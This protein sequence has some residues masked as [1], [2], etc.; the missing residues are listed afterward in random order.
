[1]SKIHLAIFVSLL[2]AAACGSPLRQ[3]YGMRGYSLTAPD[4]VKHVAVL[5]WA[6]KD[7]PRLAELLAREASDVIKLRRD[8]LVHRV[9]AM[10]HSW[11][12]LCHLPEADG[13]A[14]LDLQG[15]IAVRLLDLTDEDDEVDMRLAMELYR[16]AD[17]ALLWRADAQAEANPA[18]PSLKELV[19]TYVQ[20]FGALAQRSAATAFVIIKALVDALPNPV[21]TDDEVGQ[22]IELEG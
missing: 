12:D 10:P 19:H 3:V 15:V 4:T 8:Y 18:D 11:A 21:L 16:C 5:A 17:G 9:E 14:A 1:M 6:P 2:L 13:S 20:S 22:K 7:D